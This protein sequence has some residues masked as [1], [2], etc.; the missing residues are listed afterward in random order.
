MK[1]TEKDVIEIIKEYMSGKC[2]RLSDNPDWIRIFIEMRNQAIAPFGYEIY[3]KYR[4][5]EADPVLD[6]EWSQAVYAQMNSW[7]YMMDV[8]QE[9]VNLLRLAGYDFAVMKG[10]ANAVQY[11]EPGLRKSGDIDFLVRWDQYEE[12]CQ[13]LLENGY[14]P[15]ED[16]EKDKHH[17]I[18]TKDSITFE[19]HKRP[20]GTKLDDSPETTALNEFFQEGLDNVKIVKYEDYYF[21]VLPDL[22]NGIMLL[23]HFAGHMRSG[24]GLRHL[25]DWMVYAK[26]NL[27]DQYWE[28]SFKYAA[29]QAGV[30]ELAKVMTYTCQRCFGLSSKLSWCRDVD[31]VLCKSF[32]NYL[33]EQG[34]FGSKVKN[35]KEVKV[36]TEAKDIRGGLK[37]AYISSLYSM[38][39]ARKYW[40]LRPLAFLYQLGRYVYFG[41]RQKDAL[42]T[43]AESKSRSDRRHAMFSDLHV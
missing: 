28:D 9:L 34:D 14:S 12:I 17:I 29:E 18:L 41:M 1:R 37:R 26:Q 38:P 43:L 19:L 3:K 21:P 4:S 24:V 36:L 25:L 2:A 42:K 6:K 31:S 7:Y 8:Q 40:V 11:P 30:A 35:D 22:Q 32:L 13:F 16:Q 20:G 33:V 27:S 5:C 10:I 39:A 23:V 15:G